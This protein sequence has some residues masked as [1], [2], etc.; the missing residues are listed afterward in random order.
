MSDAEDGGV[1]IDYVKIKNEEF[2]K[3]KTKLTNLIHSNTFCGLCLEQGDWTWHVDARITIAEL[4]PQHECTM[5][6]V[7]EYLFGEHIQESL[8]S[9][10]ICE[11]C[12]DK[13]V[14]AYLFI[15]K[16]KKTSRILSTCVQNIS[17]NIDQTLMD[18]ELEQY[19]K[20]IICLSLEGILDHENVE[21]DEEQSS[22]YG[23]PKCN[24]RFATTTGLSKHID[25]MHQVKP[26]MKHSKLSIIKCN[27]CDLVLLDKEL[28]EHK[29]TH[30][31][32]NWV[33]GVCDKSFYSTACF[34]SHIRDA[35]DK[36]G[37]EVTTCDLCL[38]TFLDSDR[39]KL[40]KCKYACTECPEMP[41]VH[42]KYLLS[43]RNQ[44]ESDVTNVQCLD[45][46]Y[47]CTKKISMISHANV[48]HLD[49]YDNLCNICG[50]SFQCKPALSQHKLK[51][52]NE[53]F[54]CEHCPQLF[55]S[56]NLLNKHTALCSI[57]ERP[58]GCDI[59]SSTFDDEVALAAHKDNHY[60][61]EFQCKTCSKG[62]N[63]E[64]DL[65]IHE[66]SHKITI[67]CSMC[68]ADFDC[69]EKYQEHVA[70]HPTGTKHMCRVCGAAFNSKLNHRKHIKWHGQSLEREQ[71]KVCLRYI[72]VSY[73]NTHMKIHNKGAKLQATSRHI[74]RKYPCDLCKKKFVNLNVLK[75]HKEIHKDH[76]CC[77]ICKKYIKPAAMERHLRTHSGDGNASKK[78]DCESCSYTTYFP[79]CMEAHT[80][81]VHLKTRPYSCDVCNKSYFCRPH[82][83]EHLKSHDTSNE[84]K[85]KCEIC[86]YM[87]ANSQC[88]KK[89]M[90]LHTGEKPYPC[91]QCEQSFITASRRQEHVIRRHGMPSVR[92]PICNNLYY[93]ARDVRT[94]IKNTHCNIQRKDGQVF[95]VEELNPE[96]RYIF[97][98]QRHPE[99]V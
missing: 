59:C 28:E 65:E 27:E 39:I 73:L 37:G 23:C 61:P 68:T 94:H 1:Q 92:C 80:N 93:S 22:D 47:T 12:T 9:A 25:L 18:C 84:F 78:L 82:L 30:V 85:K 66:K 14:Q 69:K 5:L 86:G 43:Y 7:L 44:K 76:V 79:A 19:E 50:V 49:R 72:N 89:H 31:V 56:L 3:W 11:E 38:K 83:T 8:S 97:R 53:S 6:H 48:D 24:R 46:D 75:R 10:L 34:E 41:C 29:K 70:S 99:D 17:E 4:G 16:T 40:H 32:K 21:V 63:K 62:F 52:H 55:G 90:R 42:H 95:M 96:H 58:Y 71:C 57:I 54:K 98:D 60:E 51:Y 45:C 36:T 2:A 13:S 74:D 81:R 15:H 67:P 91:P 20:S 64:K 77:E 88:L 87:L 35:H 26:L 33:C